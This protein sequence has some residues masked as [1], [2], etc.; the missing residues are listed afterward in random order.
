MFETFKLRLVTSS[1]LNHEIYH[2]EV[3]L[4]VTQI[5]QASHGLSGCSELRM[6]NGDKHVV[7]MPADE[8]VKLVRQAV[9]ALLWN[10]S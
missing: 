3:Y 8:V 7:D 5:V 6:S 4:N 2:H 9:S 1:V 10:N